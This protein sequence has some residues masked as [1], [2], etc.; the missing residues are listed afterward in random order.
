LF[1][2]PAHNLYYAEQPELNYRNPEVLEWLKG[3][4]RFWLE[5]GIDGF[6]V[7]VIW[8]MLKDLDFRDEEINHEWDGKHPHEQ[9]KRMYSGNIDGIHDV[10]REMRSVFEEFDDRV[11]IG[12]IYLPYEELI[13]VDFLQ[14]TMYPLSCLIAP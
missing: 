9:L 8:L 6:R 12:E 4:I 14:F 5:I 2:D 3:V 13:K 7:D 11:M 10:I 1:I